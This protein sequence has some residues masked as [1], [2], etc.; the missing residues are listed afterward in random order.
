VSRPRRRCRRS[1]E[2]SLLWRVNYSSRRENDLWQSF[3][4]SGG[5]TETLAKFYAQESTT[6]R[7]RV[8]RQSVSSRNI[9]RSRHAL[10]LANARGH[11]DAHALLDWLKNSPEDL[12]RDDAPEITFS[13]TEVPSCPPR[14]GFVLTVSGPHGPP[15]HLGGP[16]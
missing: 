13:D 3:V 5:D 12:A 11:R 16:S 1:W 6:R 2:T 7:L 9:R 8:I 15:S 10:M 4:I 14:D